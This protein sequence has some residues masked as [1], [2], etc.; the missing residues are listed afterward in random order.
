[1]ESRCSLRATVGSSRWVV[2]GADGRGVPG[3]QVP[4]EF[5]KIISPH[6]ELEILRMWVNRII[7]TR[8][9]HPWTHFCDTV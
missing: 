4:I 1:M 6:A 5:I 7:A 8:I 9:R 2:V 3:H